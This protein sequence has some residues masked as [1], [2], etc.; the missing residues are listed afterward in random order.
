MCVGDIVMFTGQGVYARWFFGQLG[1]AE[2]VSQSKSGEW[3]CRVKWMQPVLYHG[4]YT[5]SSDFRVD[6][7]DVIK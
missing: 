6:N 4:R 3:H 7:F 5:S 2:S 1:I